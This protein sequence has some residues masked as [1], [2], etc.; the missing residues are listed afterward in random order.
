MTVS[1]HG[2]TAYT[3]GLQED[4]CTHVAKHI[5]CHLVLIAFLAML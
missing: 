1:S 4:L 2:K 5:T 3:A